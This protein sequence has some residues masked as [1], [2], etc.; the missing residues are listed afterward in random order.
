V[1]RTANSA[2][3]TRQSSLRSAYHHFSTPPVLQ[4]Y[5][6]PNPY[7]PPKH[8]SIPLTKVD[9]GAP[10]LQYPIRA[11]LAVMAIHDPLSRHRPPLAPP[12]FLAA[13]L[14]APR[15][16]AAHHARDAQP[17]RALQPGAVGRVSAVESHIVL[18]VT[19]TLR[20]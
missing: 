15:V 20:E 1:T 19:R 2:R 16:L 17:E 5:K 10:P 12:S 9:S 6:G 4:V 14:H 18:T 8:P 11:R 13:H 7:A 3:Y